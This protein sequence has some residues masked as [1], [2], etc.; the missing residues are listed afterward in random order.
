MTHG[1]VLGVYCER[2]RPHDVQRRRWS[3]LDAS[4]DAWNSQFSSRLASYA[5]MLTLST[6][7]HAALSTQRSIGVI[8]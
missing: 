5:A 1:G 3:G 4:L 7:R 8:T 6:Q 2:N